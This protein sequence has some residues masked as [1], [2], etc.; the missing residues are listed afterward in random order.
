MEEALAEK[1]DAAF[2]KASA[3]SEEETNVVLLGAAE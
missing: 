1:L 3:S 2:I